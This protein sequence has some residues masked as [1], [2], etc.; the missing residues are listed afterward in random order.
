MRGRGAKSGR[1]RQGEK[2]KRERGIGKTERST[3][4]QTR[5]SR[6][7]GG[8]GSVDCLAGGILILGLYTLSPLDP[9]L[10]PKM[11][12]FVTSRQGKRMPWW[13]RIFPVCLPTEYQA[14]S[15]QVTRENRVNCAGAVSSGLWYLH[16]VAGA[17]T[18]LSSGVSSGVSSPQVLTLRV[19]DFWLLLPLF[20]NILSS[21]IGLKG[22]PPV[23]V[24]F[25]ITARGKEAFLWAYSL[26]DTVPR[27]GEGVVAGGRS[28]QMARKKRV[29]KS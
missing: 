3:Q 1:Q 13:K 22:M 29:D 12:V 17:F 5:R 4:T 28:G 19:G 9:L 7:P 20:L 25:L 21:S 24:T 27:H 16:S 6:E 26:K 18:R 14:D 10:C 11:A 2:Q 23:L 8:R 15:L